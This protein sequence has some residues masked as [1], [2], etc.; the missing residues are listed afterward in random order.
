MLIEAEGSCLL[1]VDIQERLMAAVRDSA[2]TIANC[3]WLIDV[4]QRLDVPVLLSEQYPKGLGHTVPELRRRVS[5]AMAKTRF[6]CAADEGCRARIEDL[7]REQLIVMGAEAHVCVLQ[8]AL[9][10]LEAGKQV[11]VVADCIASRDP[12][13]A[14][15][16]I[17]RMR[18]EGV[19]IVS[20]EMVAFE[21]L[22]EAGTERFKSISR[23]FLR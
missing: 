11:F 1:G 16:A 21:W 5:E 4:A 13:N 8:T 9:G 12:R 19:R 10:L 6:S 7:G 3:A 20:R 17:A 2:R 23:E 15:L 18:A 22:Y 14:E